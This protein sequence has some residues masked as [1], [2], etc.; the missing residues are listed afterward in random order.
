MPFWPSAYVLP[1]AKF[2][3]TGERWPFTRTYG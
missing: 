1:T 3:R 2:K